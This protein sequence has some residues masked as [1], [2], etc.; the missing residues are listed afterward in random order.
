MRRVTVALCAL[1]A[2]SL[3]TSPVDARAPQRE[4]FDFVFEFVDDSICGFPIEFSFDGSGVITRYFDEEHNPTRVHIR[5]SDDARAKNVETGATAT[6]HEVSSVWVDINDGTET[7]SG[8][9]IHLKAPGH[10]SILTQAGRV[11]FDEFG[12]PTFIAGPHQL[13]DGDFTDFC[14]ALI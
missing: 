1:A 5:T 8:V 3:T 4:G 13:S 12:D 14:A 2:I 7:S 6:G 9:P 10:G 11:E